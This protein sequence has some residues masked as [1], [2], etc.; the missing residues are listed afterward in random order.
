MDPKA[1]PGSCNE[2]IAHRSCL[3]FLRAIGGTVTWFVTNEACPS[4]GASAVE[5][6]P[7]RRAAPKR[8]GRPVGTGPVPLVRTP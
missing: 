2:D 6:V 7:V 8:T 4:K 3:P 1:K 5:T